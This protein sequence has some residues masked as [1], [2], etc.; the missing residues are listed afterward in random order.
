MI[1]HN[2]RQIQVTTTV[3]AGTRVVSPI[4][5]PS[6]ISPTSHQKN[7][8]LKISQKK[9]VKNLDVEL[10]VPELLAEYKAEYINADE[11]V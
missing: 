7:L 3:D 5:P 8:Q 1:D 10:M 6:Y 2:P 9:N 4:P 11:F